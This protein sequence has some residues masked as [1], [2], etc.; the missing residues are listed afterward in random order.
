MAPASPL[1]EGGFRSQPI[2]AGEFASFCQLK[3]GRYKYKVVRGAPQVS[4]VAGAKVLEGEIAVS[5][6]A[7]AEPQS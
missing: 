6:T 4:G 2:N 5:E 7:G 1:S 3:P